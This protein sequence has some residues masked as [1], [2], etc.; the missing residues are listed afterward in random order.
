VWTI[1]TILNGASKTLT[2]VATVDSGTA[3]TTITNTAELTA[4]NE[5]DPDSTPGN[6]NGAEDDQDDAAIT[7]V[8][9][10]DLSVN[11]IVNDS[12]PAESDTI[13]YTITV[14]NGGPNT[15]TGVVIND[16]QGS[17]MSPTPRAK[18]VT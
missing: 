13:T 17:R 7:V 12:T 1:G 14:T 10:A 8:A 11:K 9:S 3:T 4:A 6:A 16:R 15:A 5:F 18:G 2:L